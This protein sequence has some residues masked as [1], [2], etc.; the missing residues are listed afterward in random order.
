MPGK[1]LFFECIKER[2][3]GLGKF[4]LN[5]LAIDVGAGTQDIFLFDD[6]YESGY[7][8]I[9][10]SPTVILARALSKIKND[11]VFTG[12][13]MGGGAITEAIEGHIE[14]GYKVA[15]TERAARTIRDNIPY[16][17]SLGI[18]IVE[19]KDA[20][21]L[22]KKGYV[23]METRD[24]DKRTINAALSAFGLPT[25]P[26]I[27]AVAVEDHGLAEKG[28][29]DRACRFRLFS[30][31]LPGRVEKFGYDEPPKNYTRMVGVKE[32]LTRDYPNAKHLIMDSKLA[33]LFGA[34]HAANVN[35]MMAID[36]G[37][38]H[39][40]AGMFEGQVLYGIFEHH[41]SALTKDTD[42]ARALLIQFA[43]GSLTQKQV[44]D[45]GGHGVFVAKALGYVP[46]YITGPRRK[47]LYSM[48]LKFQFLDPYGD[49]MLT[50]DVGLV[51]CAK[52][53]YRL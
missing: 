6:A 39:T 37:N 35:E 10:P 36:V 23:H 34:N 31:M 49:V 11:V 3:V 41:T 9:V 40:T 21:S 27:I 44:I 28:E 19:E 32:T 2:G 7:K 20:R 25:E 16:V 46:T 51:E 24:V 4:A 50:G 29:K 12:E 47:E 18:S 13:T 52:K 45:D 8:L 17:E 1:A 53:K 26:K 5:V 33:A 22:V 43:D 30:K 48:K 15:M 42:H 38:G 14:K